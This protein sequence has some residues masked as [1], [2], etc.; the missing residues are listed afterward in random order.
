MYGKR[1]TTTSP[2]EVLKG[3]KIKLKEKWNKQDWEDKTIDETAS[4]VQL[5]FNTYN[6]SKLKCE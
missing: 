6:L 2:G 3:F 1:L 5:D 4:R